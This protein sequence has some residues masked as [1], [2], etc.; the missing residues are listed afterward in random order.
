MSNFKILFSLVLFLALQCITHAQCAECEPDLTCGEGTGLPS[1]CPEILPSGVSGEYYEQIVSVFMPAFI[2]IQGITANLEEIVIS[3]I[4]GVPFGMELTLNDDDNVFFPNQGENYACA[5]LCGTPLQDGFF[6]II[7]SAVVTATVL[8]TEQVITQDFNVPLVIEE[9]ELSNSSFSFSDATGC[10]ELQIDFQALIDGSP[11]PTEYNWNFGNGNLSS[12]AIPV[13]QTYGVGSY[14]ASLETTVFQFILSEVVVSSLDGSGSNDID[15]LFGVLNQD[16]YLVVLNDQGVAVFTSESVNGSNSAAFSGLTIVLNNPGYSIQ[17]W[18]SDTLSA[19]DLVG[20]YNLG[21]LIAGGFSFSDGGTQGSLVIEQVVSAMF[22]DSQEIT[23]FEIPNGEFQYDEEENTLFYDD[24]SLTSFIWTLNGDTI[25]NNSPQQNINS[26]GVYQCEVTSEFGCSSTSQEFIVC[27]EIDVEVDYENEILFTDAGFETYS[28]SYNGLPIEDQNSETILYQGP[29]NYSVTIITSYGCEV[30]SEVL[31]IDLS[32]EQITA[33]DFSLYP[34]PTTD[35]ITIS[36]GFLDQ[37]QLI[38]VFDTS[39]KLVLE[40]PA[41]GWLSD[42][43]IDVSNLPSGH[44]NLVLQSFKG[45]VSSK[46]FQ[47]R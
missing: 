29:G 47:K 41:L 38:K 35:F 6:E 34:N 5:T 9:G 28:W 40:K 15:E 17:I 4:N 20:E 18:D 45:V 3:S 43:S 25:N 37:I 46:G 7:L 24:P 1:L 42:L 16:P 22:T 8:G 36:S 27:P 19:D 21:D 2:E 23:V 30:S 44:Y 32:I 26:F 13:T 14:T 11:N 39:G 31:S 33:L 12:D 10:G